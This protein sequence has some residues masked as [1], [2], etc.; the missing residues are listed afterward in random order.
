M[1]TMITAALLAGGTLDAQSTF[2]DTLGLGESRYATMRMLFE[3]TIFKVD[4][5]TLEVRFGPETAARLQ[6]LAEGRRRTSAL[7]DSI[8]AVALE[9]DDAFIRLHFERNVSLDQFLNGVRGNTR[10]ARDAGIITPE[11]YDDLTASLPMWYDFLAERGIKDGD[12][13]LYRIR[14]DSLYT[15]Y[16]TVEGDVPLNQVDVGDFR[17]RSVLGGYFAPR[18]EFR[19]KLIE[20]LFRG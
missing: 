7:A 3:K 13:M 12:E 4:V 11:Q 10:A 1:I 5:L 15:M 6:A 17:R 2:P 19:A 20:S 16:R 9:A 8:A 18:S 14:G